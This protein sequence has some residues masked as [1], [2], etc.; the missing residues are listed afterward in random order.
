MPRDYTKYY[1][2]NSTLPLS[3]RALAF[4]I[5]KTYNDNHKPTFD[6]IKEIFPD[7]VQ[8]SKGFIRK[9]SEEYDPKRFHEEALIS[10]DNVKYLVSNQWGAKNISGLLKKGLVL[11]IQIKEFNK[12]NDLKNTILTTVHVLYY[13]EDGYFGKDKRTG[14]FKV[15]TSHDENGNLIE[16]FHY[17]REGKV[18]RRL[19]YKY[20]SKNNLLEHIEYNS[21]GKTEYKFKHDSYGNHYKEDDKTKFDSKGRLKQ[22]EVFYT[23]GELMYKSNY[24]YNKDSCIIR[25]YSKNG[26]LQQY[27]K[28]DIENNIIERKEW[29]ADYNSSY[30][31]TGMKLFIHET[32]EYE[33]DSFNNWIKRTRYR[34]ESLYEI[35]ERKIV[36]S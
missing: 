31:F 35:A 22:R 25:K 1:I 5:V 19:V 9:K 10:S 33:Y 24:D 6:K 34:N 21:T 11:G 15:V 16:S 7:Q 36:Y 4:E 13:E 27:T 18:W 30:D 23:S 8:G 32:F 2:N 17:D 28:S 29:K 26:N 3:K 12:S 14:G 20:D